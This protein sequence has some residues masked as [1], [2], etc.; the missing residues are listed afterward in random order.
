MTTSTEDLLDALVRRVRRA[1]FLLAFADAALVTAMGTL[2][3]AL[4]LRAFGIPC[5]PDPRWLWLLAVPCAWASLAAWRSR[6]PRD[7]A[8]LWLD[9]KLGLHGLLVTS[10]ETGSTTWKETVATRLPEGLRVLPRLASRKLARRLAPALLVAAIL[11]LLPE[12]TIVPSRENPLVAHALH[13]LEQRLEQMA[14]DD[15]VPEPVRQELK[16]RLDKLAAANSR[17][18]NVEWSDVDSLSERTKRALEERH[19][20]VDRLADALRAATRP[21]DAAGTDARIADALRKLRES[22]AAGEIPPDLAKKLEALAEGAEKLSEA[23][24]LAQATELLKQLEAAQSALEQMDPAALEAL[25][26]ELSESDHEHT[27][28]CEDGH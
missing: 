24:R 20:T 19:Q 26:G 18:E 4:I 9:T 14:K 21:S 12:L 13:E 2:V 23:E 7:R 15:V 17:G 5:R 28:A 16:D 25:E 6:L 11:A 22:G 10:L 8:A 1:D 3:T 27:E